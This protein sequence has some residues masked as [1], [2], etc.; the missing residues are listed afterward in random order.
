MSIKAALSDD[1]S[2]PAT[3]RLPG[4]RDVW[5]FILAELLM[6]GTFFVAYIVNWMG[7]VGGYGVA[8]HP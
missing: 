1:L 8:A 4:D 2:I 6:F 7:D 3:R 5:I